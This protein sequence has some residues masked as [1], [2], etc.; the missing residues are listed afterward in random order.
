MKTKMSSKGQ[1]V[2]PVEFRELDQIA[3][4]QQFI[5]ERVQPGE[6]LL[7]KTAEPGASGLVQWLR[8]CPDQEWFQAVESESTDTL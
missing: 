5:V 2:L 8:D 6:Y 7:R 4:G 3:V 1:V